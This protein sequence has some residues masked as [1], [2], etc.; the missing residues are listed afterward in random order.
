ML[1]NSNQQTQSY[2]FNSHIAARWHW[3]VLWV[4]PYLLSHINLAI[5]ELVFVLNMNG[6]FPDGL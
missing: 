5:G 6:I 3:S 1:A 4:E 2:D